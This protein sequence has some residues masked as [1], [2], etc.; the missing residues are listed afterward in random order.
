MFKRSLAAIAVLLTAAQ[1]KLNEDFA[2]QLRGE[3]PIDD[4][5]FE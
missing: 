2:A 5:V 3:A 1:A 4:A